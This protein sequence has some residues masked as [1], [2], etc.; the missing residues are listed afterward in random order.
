M[1]IHDSVPK[2]EA[3]NHEIWYREKGPT[4]SQPTAQLVHDNTSVF[5]GLCLRSTGS[6][7]GEIRIKATGSDAAGWRVCGKAA[8]AG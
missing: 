3:H 6:H 8:D 5:A 2:D 1:G 7:K 4:T